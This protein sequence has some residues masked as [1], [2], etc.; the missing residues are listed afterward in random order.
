MLLNS[1][2]HSYG[3]KQGK[4]FMKTPKQLQP[5]VKDGLIDDVIRRLK[6]G[7]EADVFIVRSNKEIRCAKVYKEI[8]KRNFKQS[9]SYKEGRKVR[10]SRDARAMKKGSKFGREQQEKAWQNTEMEALCL[11]AKAGV[12]VPNPDICVNGVLLMELITDREGR[13]AP[14]LNDITLTPEQARID[15]SLIMQ[16]AMRML[17]V[18]V[19][20]GDLSEFNV[21]VDSNGPVII[22][23]PQVVYTTYNNH[24][25][26]MFERDVNN[27][28]RY[29]GQYAPELLN[30]RYAQEIWALY[31]A[32]NLTPESVLCGE[33]FESSRDVNIDL[34]L[35]EIHIVRE[36]HMRTLTSNNEKH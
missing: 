30:S 36:E 10:N 31:Q 35:Q 26:S 11:L 28:S 1:T 4:D 32:G 29:Y 14:R 17:C 19:V 16:Y 2:N 8:E 3:P 23:L 27:I 24:A 7:K 5:L 15:H 34:V 9:T 33:F 20:H 22:D 6:S 12:R 18:G 25:K 13:V 21:L